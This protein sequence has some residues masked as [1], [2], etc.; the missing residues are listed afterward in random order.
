MLV[1]GVFEVL[2][3]RA[4]RDHRPE[5]PAGMWPP[6]AGCGAGRRAADGARL[7]AECRVRDAVDRGVLLLHADVDAA[8]RILSRCAAISASSRRMAPR[9]CRCC[10][11]TAFFSRQMWGGSPTASAG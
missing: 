6:A 11:A 2:V 3:D 10:S 5:A 8:G 1:F 9:C 7:A 4:D